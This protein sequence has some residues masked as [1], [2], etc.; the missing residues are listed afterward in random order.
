MASGH[1]SEE[2]K[3]NCIGFATSAMNR[4]TISNALPF[5]TLHCAQT[6]ARTAGQKS[7]RKDRTEMKEDYDVTFYYVVIFLAVFFSFAIGLLGSWEMG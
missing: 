1:T 6:F 5:Q 3:M 2:L 4:F 7:I